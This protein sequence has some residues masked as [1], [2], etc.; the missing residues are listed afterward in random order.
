[1][2]LLISVTHN[3]TLG[4]VQEMAHTFVKWYYELLNSKTSDFRPDHFFP[5]ASAKITLSQNSTENTEFLHVQ[6]NGKQV[7]KEATSFS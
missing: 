4:Q 1:M 6:D 2:I 7:M 3:I 5:D